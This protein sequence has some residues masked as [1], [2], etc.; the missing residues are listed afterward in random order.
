MPHKGLTMLEINADIPQETVKAFE[1]AF[2]R[3]HTVL[4]NGMGTAIR[5][6]FSALCRSLI[7]RTKAAPKLVPRT[8]V[9]RHDHNVLGGPSYITPKGH[10]QKPV[11]RW[12]ITRR[13]KSEDSWG[14]SVIAKSAA[15]ARKEYG[16]IKKAGLAKQSWSVARALIASRNGN[17]K[18]GLARDGTVRGYV[19]EYVTGPNQRVEALLEN[20]L[21]YIT[22]ATPEGVVDEAMRAATRTI[23][24]IINDKLNEGLK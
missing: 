6:G 2:T 5:R 15:Q 22:A 13:E 8:S 23:E 7:A 17:I 10:K 18:H 11:P 21:K 16:K 24:A 20:N 12:R 1:D 14:Y 9:Q 3:F 19:R 4:G